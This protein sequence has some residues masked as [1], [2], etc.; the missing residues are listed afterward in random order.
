M[1]IYKLNVYRL[2]SLIVDCNLQFGIYLEFS[3]FGKAKD[4][5][6][7]KIFYFM[8]GE[9]KGIDTRYTFYDRNREK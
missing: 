5:I 2:L 7:L 6:E 9:L 4:E 8:K 3:T 1:S